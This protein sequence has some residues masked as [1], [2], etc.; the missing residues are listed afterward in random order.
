[1]KRRA[2]KQF[3][4]PLLFFWL[5]LPLPVSAQSVSDY[6]YSDAQDTLDAALEEAPSFADLVSL[7]FSGDADKALRQFPAYLKSGLL[8]EISVSRKSLGQVLLIAAFG[9]VFSGLADAFQDKQAGEAGFYVTYLLLL[10]LLFTAFQAALSV[11]EETVG[12]VT[13][14]MGA[15]LPAFTLSVAATGK[16][17]TSLF[18][19]EFILAAVSIVEWSFRVFFLPGIRIYVVLSLVNHISEEDI[20]TKLTELLELGLSWS[21]KALVGLVAGYGAVQSLVL[22]M[23]DSLKTGAVTRVLSAIPGIGTGA[24]AAASLIAGTANLI[25]NSIG[26]A[27]LAVL[28]LLA[29]VPVLKLAV[30]TVLYHGAAAIVQPVADERV[31]ECLAAMASAAR[32]LLKLTVSAV[33]LFLLAVG[34]LCA[35]PPS[36]L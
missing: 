20:L 22:P 8:S 4:L 14:F 19:Y 32:L 17:L 29:A 3:L 23:A 13:A 36:G 6:D 24:G 33:G 1:M 28:V 34:L 26:A 18:S 35:F 9:A 10:S 11:A 7:F 2:G 25:K 5:L 31:T 12:H 16:T 21:L 27:A 30:I 15:L